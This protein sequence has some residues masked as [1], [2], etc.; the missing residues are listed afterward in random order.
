M[1][2]K[3]IASY[4]WLL[5]PICLFFGINYFLDFEGVYGQDAYE[6][7]R[8]TKALKDFYLSGTDPGDYF[9]PVNYPL[10]S[11]LLNLLFSTSLSCQLVSLLSFLG[12]CIYLKKT[13]LF[14][15]PDAKQ[16]HINLYLITTVLF[17]PYFF[18]GS[19]LCM[20]DMMA[21]FF[22]TM[23]LYH[24]ITLKDWPRGILLIAIA[25]AIAICTRYAGIV[26]L[27]PICTMAV[28]ELYFSQKKTNYIFFSILLGCTMLIPQY[29]LKPGATNAFVSHEF[30]SSWSLQNFFNY[31][32]STNDGSATNNVPNLVYVFSVFAH[33]GYF[34]AGIPL[35]IGIRKESFKGHQLKILLFIFI[36]L[37]FLAGIPF[38]NMRF[39]MIVFPLVIVFHFPSYLRITN[40][41]NKRLIYLSI[42]ALIIMQSTVFT[43]SFGKMYTRSR[44]E[45]EIAAFF[46]QQDKD[47]FIYGYSYDVPLPYYGV[48]Q[49]IKNLFIERYETY[50]KGSYV[51]FNPD[52]FKSKLEGRNPLLNWEHLNNN[53]SLKTIK[54]F[55]NG[56]KVYEIR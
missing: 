14:L 17:S 42:F 2:Q 22:I 53:Y 11:S 15:Y 51:L 4:W 29:L 52:E 49:R 43:Y 27:L 41:I 46:L 38:Q 7:V 24:Y 9:W 20:S 36:Y 26:I 40:M 47:K 35:L 19:I 8:Y 18:R 31:E 56:W 45:K 23:S 44:Q 55:S 33:P 25:S 34:L 3:N 10:F 6:Y 28:L 13:L 30:I 12:I 54:E 5:I 21:A 50:E 37:L 32:F 16:V 48:K 1:I 39:L